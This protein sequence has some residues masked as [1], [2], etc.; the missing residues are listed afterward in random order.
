M[1][2][3]GFERRLSCLNSE[4]KTL[5][6]KEAQPVFPWDDIML[7]LPYGYPG[8]L[9]LDQSGQSGNSKESQ[10]YPLNFEPSS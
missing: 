3:G 10:R 8:L 5:Y 4:K 9:W 6:K 1:L 2:V 7:I